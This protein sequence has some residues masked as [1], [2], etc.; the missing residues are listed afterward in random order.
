MRGAVVLGVLL[1]VLG[2]VGGAKRVR[3]ADGAGAEQ[4]EGSRGATCTAP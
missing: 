4:A 2:V 3:V 1:K